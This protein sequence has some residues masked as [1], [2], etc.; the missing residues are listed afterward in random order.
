MIMKEKFDRSVPHRKITD[1]KRLSDIT[2]EE[3]K[4][5]IIRTLTNISN[6]PMRHEE[7]KEARQTAEIPVSEIARAQEAAEAAAA[8]A[9]E[10]AAQSLERMQKWAA[11]KRKPTRQVDLSQASFINQ[12]SRQAAAGAR[13]CPRCW[14]YNLKGKTI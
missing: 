14:R 12:C 13:C 3:K 11:A 6:I 10:A 5:N 1:I 8:M 2:D 7:V 9:E 4:A